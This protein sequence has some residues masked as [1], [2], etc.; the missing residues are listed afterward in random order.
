[1]RRTPRARSRRQFLRGSLA[2]AGLSL[3]S[4]CGI[5]FGPSA[6][7]G[8]LYRVGCLQSSTPPSTGGEPTLEAFR[9]GLREHGYIEGRQVVL[10]VRY[11]EG[12][13]ERLPELAAELVGLHVDV[14]MT[15]GGAS[16]A[17]VRAAQQ[18]TSTIPIVFVNVVDPVASGLVESLARPGGNVTG[19]TQS[20]GQESAKRL[21]LLQ[22]VLPGLSRVA[23]WGQQSLQSTFRETEVAAQALGLEVLSL[24]LSGPDD[25]GAVQ[26]ATI[27]GR[28]DGLIGLPGPLLPQLKPQILD[29]TARHRLPAMY[30]QSSW[31]R[32]GGLMNYGPSQAENYRRAAYY[33]D[34]ILKGAKP[35]DLPVEQPSRFEFS[36]NLQTAQALGLTIP[37]SVLQ[38]ATEV[39]E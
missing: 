19:L 25:L 1:M 6:R 27:T 35:A 38:Q 29:F 5:P 20:A 31:A 33:V 23:V 21:Q 34:R 30:A 26:A 37:R 14:I 18:A 12:R 22:E 9:Q 2:V 16:G 36:I 7:R 8:E 32:D 4:G 15:G 3:L 10:E 17:T 28:A 13:D 11:S 24:V 39:I